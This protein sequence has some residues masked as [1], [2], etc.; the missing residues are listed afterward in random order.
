MPRM[1][2]K[3][4]IFIAS[5]S[6][7]VLMNASTVCS[8]AYPVRPI[9]LVVG[10]STGSA[11]DATARTIS[12]KLTDVLGR[13][14]VVENRAGAAGAIAAD[15][16]AKSPADG[17]VLLL[18]TAADT[19][20]PALRS[21]LP[22]DL[23]RDFAPVSLVSIGPLLLVVNAAVPA[24]SVKELIALAQARPGK[25]SYGSTGV[26]TM[27]HLAGEL[28]K[29]KAKVDITHVPYKGG[30]ESAMATASGQI[31]MTFPSIPAAIPLIDAGK[32]RA[33]AISGAK[34]V[35]F[36]PAVP[37]FDELGFSG[38]DRSSWYGV[39]A[40]A[41]VP[42]ETIARL[43]GAIA[44]VLGMPEV[45][46]ALSRDGTEPQPNTPEQFAAFINRELAQNAELIR[47]T[48]AKAE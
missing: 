36:M 42:R 14:M 12:Q 8:Q 38:Y 2:W 18:V 17:Y 1:S 41:G 21:N 24:Q 29:F 39:L 15:L 11:A 9:R 22:Y 46:E 35:P 33:L 30:A 28:F 4:L 37:T 20:Q 31:E 7:A 16:V 5:G 43:N 26:G 47:L 48:G 34:R 6:A 45:R 19:V 3:R 25:L 44:K 23:V 40:P 10:V 32:L 27:T 13:A